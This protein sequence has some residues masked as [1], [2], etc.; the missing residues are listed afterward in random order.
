MYT[1]LNEQKTYSNKLF[2]YIIRKFR[3]CIKCVGIFTCKYA[4]FIK[5]LLNYMS[6]WICT[7]S[8]LTSRAS[9]FYWWGLCGIPDP[10]R[11]SCD[12]CLTWGPAWHSWLQTSST[13]RVHQEVLLE[14]MWYLITSKLELCESE[15]YSPE[16]WAVNR[17]QISAMAN[18]NTNYWVPKLNRLQVIERTRILCSR[19]LWPWPLTCWP[20]NKKA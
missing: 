19:W 7:F 14:N 4:R 18:L 6:W 16:G 1:N 12:C 15:H 8:N 17:D 3:K 10:W 9:Q 13:R 5:H 11:P 20:Q 2:S